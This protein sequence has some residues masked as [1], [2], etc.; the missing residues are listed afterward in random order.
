MD[1]VFIVMAGE[2]CE[3]GA[4]KGVF[5]TLYRA[6]ALVWE[7]LEKEISLYPHEWISEEVNN[8]PVFTSK[9]FTKLYGFWEGSCDW[10]SLREYWVEG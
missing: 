2:H 3:G 9:E 4:I 7:L 8:D 1:T 5:S 6:R 10:I